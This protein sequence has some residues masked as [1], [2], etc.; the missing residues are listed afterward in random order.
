MYS[1]SKAKSVLFINPL[2]TMGDA[3]F[4]S[5]VFNALKRDMPERKISV[6]T[7]PYSQVFLERFESVDRVFN[8]RDYGVAAVSSKTSK[9]LSLIRLSLL[10]NRF[11]AIILRNDW[12]VPHTRLFNTAAALSGSDGVLKVDK[13]IDKHL[14]PHRHIVET[15]QRILLDLNIDSSNSVNFDL[16]LT[17]RDKRF[18]EDFIKSRKLNGRALL[19]ICPTS[20]I[21]IK[22]LR[23][24]KIVSLINS[25]SLREYEILL[26]NTDEKANEQILKSLK[27]EPLIVGKT[28]FDNLISLISL[29]DLFVS[30]DTGP[31][32]IAAALG[33]PSLGIFGP[34]SGMVTGPY[35]ERCHFIEREKICGIFDPLAP[36]SPLKQQQACYKL[37]ECRLNSR[38]CIDD[39]TVKEILAGIDKIALPS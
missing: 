4:L 28:D 21:G 29:C 15:F 17:E 3:I 33:I 1:L 23:T 9:L 39:I 34:T 36:Y 5:S 22:S 24:D 30:V 12:R 7:N 18:R 19:G 13:Y 26:L 20:G 16:S 14:S 11:D 6:I 10:I 38:S 25:D 32:H 2:L 35:G 8:L 31:L 37:D 27:R